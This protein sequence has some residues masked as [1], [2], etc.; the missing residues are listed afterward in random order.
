MVD[1]ASIHTSEAFQEAIPQWETKGLSIFYLPQY[2][3]EL[4]LIE[5]LWRFMK[6]EWIEFWAYTSFDHLFWRMSSATEAAQIDITWS[7]TGNGEYWPCLRISVRRL[8]RSSW[9]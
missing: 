7:S 2:S 3:P 4:N 6:Y 9:S 1:N 8:P 5:I